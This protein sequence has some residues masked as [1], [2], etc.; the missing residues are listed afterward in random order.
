[1]STERARS[2]HIARALATIAVVEQAADIM[3]WC[4]RVKA[5]GHLLPGEANEIRTLREEVERKRA[6]YDME[7]PAVEKMRALFFE[8]VGGDGSPDA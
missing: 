2:Y 8:V 6:A 7:V 4:R 5:R 3:G 1:M